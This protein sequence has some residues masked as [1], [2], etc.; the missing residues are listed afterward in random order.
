MPK[1]LTPYISLSRIA[2]K[3]YS[4]R[5]KAGKDGKD[6]TPTLSYMRISNEWRAGLGASCQEESEVTK[7]SPM[8]YAIGNIMVACM[9]A[10]IRI[11]VTRVD[12]LIDRVL[13]DLEQGIERK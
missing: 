9:S 5:Q 10:L 6:I 1:K 4:A 11:G 2:A 13:C 8:A 12:L 3:A 7:F